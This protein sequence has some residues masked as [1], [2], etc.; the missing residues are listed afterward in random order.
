VHHPALE[1]HP[2][3]SRPQLDQRLEHLLL[4]AHLRLNKQLGH[5]VLKA[6]LNS[7][8]QLHPLVDQRARLPVSRPHFSSLLHLR[9]RPDLRKLQHLQQRL[10]QPHQ[11]RVLQH[12]TLP[13]VVPR[14]KV[15]RHITPPKVVTPLR[16]LQNMLLRVVGSLQTHQHQVPL[17]QQRQPPVQRRRVLLL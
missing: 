10:V 1:A 17:L 12:M 13:R 9:P 3:A 5:L 16:V 14:L 11:P 7:F 4:K 15:L 6:R 8:H 2:P